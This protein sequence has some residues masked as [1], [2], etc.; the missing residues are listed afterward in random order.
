MNQIKCPHC[1][2]AFTIDKAS[3]AD[4]QNQVRTREFES[5]IQSRVKQLEEKYQSVAS[6]SA[7]T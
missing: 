5:E 6:S 4:I 2:T 3:Y 7:T 1:Q